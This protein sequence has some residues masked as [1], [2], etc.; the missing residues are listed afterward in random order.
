[1]T[2]EWA[3]LIDENLEPQI[4]TYLEKED[5]TADHVLGVLFQGADDS[6]DILPYLRDHDRIF[7]TNDVSHFSD[8]PDEDH[9]GIIIVYDGELRAF[10]ITAGILEIVDTYPD[11]DSFRGY[12]ILDDWL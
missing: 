3:F 6:D 12:E 1:M 4:A 9:E 5:L 2:G 11:R 8:V 7:V 10:E